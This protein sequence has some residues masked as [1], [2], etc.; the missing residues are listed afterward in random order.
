MTHDGG[1]SWV[2]SSVPPPSGYAADVVIYGPPGPDLLVAGSPVVE[3]AFSDPA[4]GAVVAIGFYVSHD[5]GNSWSLSGV[6]KVPG[7][8]GNAF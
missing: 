3:A 5:L 8:N 7:P 1:T 2:A 4:S 6:Y